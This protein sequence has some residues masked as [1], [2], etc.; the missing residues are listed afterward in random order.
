[1]KKTPLALVL[2]LLGCASACASAKTPPS[3]SLDDGAPRLLTAFF[4]LDDALPPAVI[5][6]CAEG[7]GRD[8]MPLVFSQRVAGPV[9]AA[10]F[11]VV[12]R[13]GAHHRPL[14][15][16]TRPADDVSERQTILLIGDL[17]SDRDDPPVSVS[18]VG[19]VAFAG[20]NA[21]GA[22]V[23][24]IPLRDGPTLALAMG[25]RPGAL[26]SDCPASAREIVVVAFTGGVV[27]APGKSNDDFRRAISVVG[28]AGERR[29]IAL[30][31]LNDN[32]NYVHVCLDRSDEGDV[33][34]NV[35]AGVVVD[36]AGDLNPATTVRV[37][38]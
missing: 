15:A 25:F 12:T 23:D 29:P 2:L 36:P 6:L 20:G 33:V 8:G 7:A 17:G 10:A 11:D 16:T 22:S 4:G 26:T 34:V 9:D 13:A 27:A 35:A 32:D 24:V 3:T 18:V 37:A 19:D 30:A 14:C 31:D 5:A 38:R 21:K 1:M 28:P